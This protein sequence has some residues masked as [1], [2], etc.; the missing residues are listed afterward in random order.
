MEWVNVTSFINPSKFEEVP[1]RFK[2]SDIT[3]Q[4]KNILEKK[5]MNA[6]WLPI[7]NN[8]ILALHVYNRN[9]ETIHKGCPHQ[10]GEGGQPNAD[11]CR[12]GGA[13]LVK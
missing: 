7:P 10:G 1:V 5:S 11:N 4:G 6:I 13:G 3:F 2:F 8:N 9:L 12:Q